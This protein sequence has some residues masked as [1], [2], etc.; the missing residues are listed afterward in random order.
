MALPRSW[1]NRFLP[2][3]F[4]VTTTIGA[5]SPFPSLTF[6]ITGW[7]LAGLLATFTLT[8][9]FAIRAWWS[10]PMIELPQLPWNEDPNPPFKF[11]A[12]IDVVA[13]LTTDATAK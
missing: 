13:I 12:E 6:F 5:N 9:D 1:L 3:R 11:A 10:S 8:A 7:H 4:L 2:M